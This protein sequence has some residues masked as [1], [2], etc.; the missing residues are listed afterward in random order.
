M[1][2]LPQSMPA[3]MKLYP[4][5]SD[6]SPLIAFALIDRFSVLRALF[7]ALWIPD[8]VYDE[9]VLAPG[10]VTNPGARPVE[11]AVNVGWIQR[12]AVHDQDAVQRQMGRLHRGE[13]EVVLGA[14]EYGIPVVLLDDRYARRLAAAYR[15]EYTETVGLLLL[16]KR[17]GMIEEVRPFLA[18][19]RRSGFRMSA[20][21]YQEV[22]HSAQKLD[23][24]KN[25]KESC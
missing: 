9:V 22:L 1:W 21:L 4:V 2:P 14:V 15:L 11:E 25:H 24:V 10:S 18:H 19:L 6:S 13:V 8:A 20:S 3:T 16:A 12:L 5:V 23:S 17:R 7:S